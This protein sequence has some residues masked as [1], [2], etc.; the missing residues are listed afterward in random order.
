VALLI[1]SMVYVGVVMMVGNSRWCTKVVIY[2]SQPMGGLKQWL[3]LQK[4]ITHY[5]RSVDGT[6]NVIR[7]ADTMVAYLMLGKLRT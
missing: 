5:D 2:C 3:L 1:Y 7:E 6:F 4:L